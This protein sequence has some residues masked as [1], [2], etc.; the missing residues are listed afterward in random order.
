MHIGIVGKSIAF[1]ALGGGALAIAAKVI[2]GVG[3]VVSSI[4]QSYFKTQKEKI[5]LAVLGTALILTMWLASALLNCYRGKKEDKG[6]N[7]P[8]TQPVRVSEAAQVPVKNSAS[9]QLLSAQIRIEH[10]EVQ[11]QIGYLDDFDFSIVIINP[12]LWKK[13]RRFPVS[14]LVTEAQKQA[15]GRYREVHNLSKARV[16]N[17]KGEELFFDFTAQAA[18]LKQ[19]EEEEEI[20]LQVAMKEKAKAEASARIN[21]PVADAD[22][23]VN[24]KLVVFRPDQ[25]QDICFGSQYLV[26]MPILLKEGYG[27][28]GRQSYFLEETRKGYYKRVTDQNGKPYSLDGN[29]ELVFNYTRYDY[30]ECAKRWV[31]QSEREGKVV[32]YDQE[33]KELGRL[34]PAFIT[35]GEPAFSIKSSY[36]PLC[37]QSGHLLQEKGQALYARIKDLEQ[38]AHGRR[39]L[40]EHF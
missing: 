16:V 7:H 31:Q 34:M 27:E 29:D 10:G 30:D 22:G 14:L 24:C 3:D 19:K 23:M 12:E 35:M 2:P 11:E 28:E 32:Y 26:A 21:E 4:E 33:G 40:A 36:I 13:G 17:E 6:V 9:S 1:L 20:A 15:D 8:S 18:W 37:D 38:I 39:L 5:G 25:S